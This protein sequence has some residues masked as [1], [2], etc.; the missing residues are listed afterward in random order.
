MTG[1]DTCDRSLDEN[2]RT[3]NLQVFVC[4]VCGEDHESIDCSVV[5][6]LKRIHDSKILSRARQTL[7][8][9]FAVKSL[10]DGSTTVITNV[11]IDQGTQFGPFQA[12]LSIDLPPAVL[13]PLK[14]FGK[15]LDD[16]Y[17]LDTSD[18]ECCNWMCL[19]APA[20]NTSEQNLICYDVK[21]SIYFATTRDLEPG[22]ELRLWYALYYGLKLQALPLSDE[23]AQEDGFYDLIDEEKQ[24]KSNGGVCMML[25]DDLL[26][27]L[28]EHLPAHALG[29]FGERDVWICKLCGVQESNV[30]SYARHLMVHY[31]Q[32]LHN[33][34]HPQCTIC[35][36]RFFS[37]KILDNHLL[38]HEK[39]NMSDIET[40]ETALNNS[41]E[42]KQF[43]ENINGAEIPS[44]EETT[45]GGTVYNNGVLNDDSKN[46]H[47]N[48]SKSYFCHEK[49]SLLNLNNGG[50]GENAEN[51]SEEEQS[52]V[53]HSSPDSFIKPKGLDMT[54]NPKLHEENVGNLISS[55]QISNTEDLVIHSSNGQSFATS[56]NLRSSQDI[57]LALENGEPLT[58]VMVEAT[59][60]NDLPSVPFVDNCVKLKDTSSV[61]NL[62]S[63]TEELSNADVSN[64]QLHQEPSE[65]QRTLFN[66]DICEKSFSKGAY[67]YRHLR[68][69]TGEFT[70]VTCLAVF[71]RKENLKTHSCTQPR[72]W[73]PCPT[74][75]RK[76]SAK[77]Y[78]QRHV[79]IHTGEFTCSECNRHFVS[80]LSLKYHRCNVSR[81]K[82]GNVTINCIMCDRIF[83]T[84]SKL[85]AH[86]KVHS[87]LKST[88]FNKPMFLKSSHN[89]ERLLKRKDV[90]DNSEK[91]PNNISGGKVF[92][93]EICGAIFKSSSSMKT[94]RFCHGER[95][96]ECSICGKRFHRKDVLQEHSRVHEEANF[97]CELC[98]KKYKTKKSLY[99]HSL[100][101]EGSKRFSCGVCAKEFFQKGNLIKHAQ[102]HTSSRIYCCQYCKKSF[103]SKEYFN[104]HQLT[105]T[106]GNIY[107]CDECKRGFVKKHL[108]DTHRQ[109]FHS[110]RGFLCKFCNTLVRH[111]H[112]MRRH[113][114]KSHNVLRDKWSMPGFIDIL[115][116]ELPPNLLSSFGDAKLTP[117]EQQERQH[118]IELL[119]KKHFQNKVASSLGPTSEFAYALVPES[120]P[121][122]F[123]LSDP[124]IMLQPSQQLALV[125]NIQ[126]GNQD[127]TFQATRQLQMDSEDAPGEVVFTL[128]NQESSPN[129]PSNTTPLLNS[130]SLAST[131]TDFDSGTTYLMENGHG[132]E[133]ILLYVVETSN[134]E[135]DNSEDF[136]MV[137]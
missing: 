88:V 132:N 31:R 4:S 41:I 57:D 108:L 46:A 114:E 45:D 111:R 136:Y 92:I 58:F 73:F 67:L 83:S 127:E 100:I 54:L 9:D 137:Q 29:A 30:A 89:V 110:N 42:Y 112:S 34:R 61:N 95:K 16:G 84:E 102:T 69:H 123:T 55:T 115:Q 49:E 78:L 117:K 90:K 22:E 59:D 10:A 44:C 39:C 64:E 6:N 21:Q 124:I 129:S 11:R 91:Q 93:C 119:R 130:S 47:I 99:V 104:I 82:S 50:K 2:C 120:Q 81:N 43:P 118:Q 7:P 97:P 3:L 74:C 134:G 98:G 18:E 96:F 131:I 65:K 15:T 87:D 75:G 105:H 133:S 26:Q 8:K 76:F 106:Q 77:K 36:R 32:P 128:V 25:G 24:G 52:E 28:T 86:L 53:S 63:N 72:E 113:L 35:F 40:S 48:R 1:D 85:R 68:K 56:I 94:H 101:H 38:K 60:K 17:Y 70:C 5:Q 125:N 19:V 33:N 20:S 79:P 135:D 80:R 109:S 116:T 13:F 14:V 71:A 12:P 51:E 66:C 107:N 37:K 122:Q 126:P 103:S 27:T 23:S 121:N 62:S